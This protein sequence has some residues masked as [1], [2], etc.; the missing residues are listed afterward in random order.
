MAA[1]LL[2]IEL[3]LLVTVQLRCGR[4]QTA[5]VEAIH[6]DQSQTLPLSLASLEG[7]RD[8]ASVRASLV[9]QGSGNHERLEIEL[10]LDLGP[11]IRLASGKF[12]FRQGGNE[13]AGTVGASSLDFQAGQSGGMSLGGRFILYNSSSEPIYRVFVPPKLLDSSYSYR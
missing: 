9:F 10:G 4:P 7:K 2:V 5:L 6:G 13:T 8:G 12:V 11:P 3:L 1:L